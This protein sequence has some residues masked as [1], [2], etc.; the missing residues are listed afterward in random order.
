MA[1]LFVLLL[2][3]VA[4]SMFLLLQIN[5]DIKYEKGFLITFTISVFELVLSPSKKR[6]GDVKKADDNTKH[7]KRLQKSQVIKSLLRALGHSRIDIQRV[8][9]PQFYYEAVPMEVYKSEA[10]VFSLLSLFI[11]Y[12]DTK[13]EK[14]YQRTEAYD[15]YSESENFVFQFSASLFLFLILR[16]VIV[17]MLKRR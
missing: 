6:G 16:E 3:T 2:L 17:L 5:V 13:T 8:V 14:L 10:L 15:T 12:L 1:L 7:K 4:V 9:I 11:A